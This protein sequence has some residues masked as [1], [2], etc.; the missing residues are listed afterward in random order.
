MGSFY[1]DIFIFVEGLENT[2]CEVCLIPRRLPYFHHINISPEPKVS[3]RSLY[4]FSKNNSKVN[5]FFIFVWA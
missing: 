4:T 2:F 5:V 1:E 3:K